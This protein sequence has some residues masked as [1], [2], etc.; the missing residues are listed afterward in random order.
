M[1]EDGLAIALHRGL[2]LATIDASVALRTSSGSRR[3]KQHHDDHLVGELRAASTE[4]QT[5]C[6]D[7][8]SLR[9]RLWNLL[10]NDYAA[11]YLDASFVAAIS[12]RR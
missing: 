7:L 12:A 5:E 1:A 3:S 10:A 8:A 6:P 9:G 4:L 11:T 2:A